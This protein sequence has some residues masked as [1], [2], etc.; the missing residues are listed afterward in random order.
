MVKLVEPGH[1]AF[2]SPIAVGA[3]PQFS[4]P[5]DHMVIP[6]RRPAEERKSILA[7]W[8]GKHSHGKCE[9]CFGHVR[10]STGGSGGPLKPV[11]LQGCVGAVGSAPAEEKWH[12]RRYS[13]VCVYH[14]L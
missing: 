8:C 4:G 11:K 2:A 13:R 3:V 9:W 10:I 14:V 7:V 1:C 12:L 5:R 6:F